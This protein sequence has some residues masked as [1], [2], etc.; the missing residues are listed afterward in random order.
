M[1][2]LVAAVPWLMLQTSGP[3]PC[4]DQTC[5]RISDAGLFSTGTANCPTFSFTIEIGGQSLT[6]SM[7]ASCDTGRREQDKDCFECGNQSRGNQCKP[8]GFP[9]KVT[10]YSIGG[11]SPCPSIPDPLPTTLAEASL[12]VSCKPLPEL[13]SEINWCAKDSTCEGSEREADPSEGDFPPT[14]LVVGDGRGTRT[15]MGENAVDLRWERG[16]RQS[17]IAAVPRESVDSLPG[18]L[19][20]A[21]SRVGGLEGIELAATLDVSYFSQG[22]PGIVNRFD[23]VAFV[24]RDGRLQV[25]RSEWLP[26]E[27]GRH[28]PAGERILHDGTTLLIEYEG[29]SV[30]HA[31]LP[32]YYD[33]PGVLRAK[34]AP[35]ALLERWLEE[36]FGALR[37]PGTAYE[38]L[39]T[40]DGYQVR[41]TYPGIHGLGSDG[42]TLY[43][44]S[45]NDPVPRARDVEHRN[46]AGALRMR[47]TLD[48]YGE[49]APDLERPFRVCE[50]YYDEQGRIELSRLLNVR[51]AHSLTLDEAR[52]RG[53]MV[54]QARE[55]LV[56]R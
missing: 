38:T 35:F 25:N 29:S 5:R 23:F 17:P 26:D 44:F 28:L 8:H 4:N 56:Y 40:E 36:P 41:E 48:T 31:Y 50:T 22:Q 7:P 55:W 3:A 10:I 51:V 9:A 53:W 32:G 6:F 1:S 46:G 34:L 39:L 30:G 21:L 45:R 16:L 43:S 42:S 27:E 20:E 11:G 15:W 49:V 37:L 47:R 24:G 14:V 33:L 12:A 54:P 52:R 13:H 2:M 19:S 18:L